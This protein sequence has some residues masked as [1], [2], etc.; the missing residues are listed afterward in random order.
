MR[1][2]TAPDHTTADPATVRSAGVLRWPSVIAT[3]LLAYLP[4][5]A[6]NGVPIGP[7]R[8]HF[9]GLMIAAGIV[10][11]V[12]LSQRRWE[13][14]GGAAGTMSALALWGVPGGLIG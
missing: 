1:P 12:W 9:Y 6:T 5:P 13:Q 4:S 7:L 14:I 8:L 3:P 2:G 11:A 10:A